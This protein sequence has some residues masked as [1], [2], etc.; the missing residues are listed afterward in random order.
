MFIIQFDSNLENGKNDHIKMK[1][2]ILI[3]VVYFY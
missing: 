1:T 3:L 2:S